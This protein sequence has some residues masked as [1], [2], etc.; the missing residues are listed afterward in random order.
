MMSKPT[1]VLRNSLISLALAGALPAVTLAAET[2]TPGT[3]APPEPKVHFS[4][5][6]QPPEAHVLDLKAPDIRTVMTADELAAATAMPP[7]EF[8]IIGPETVAV[9]GAPQPVYVPSGFA[10]LYWAAIHPLSAW[11]I[12][13]PVQ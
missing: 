10:A 7:D 11:R 12:L 2:L 9:H 1:E 5:P 8:E 6:L 3:S 13:T 4:V